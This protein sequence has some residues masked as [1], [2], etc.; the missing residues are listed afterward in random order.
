MRE[1]SA[2]HLANKWRFFRFFL[3]RHQH[4]VRKSH[5]SSNAHDT[6]PRGGLPRCFLAGKAVAEVGQMMHA[7]T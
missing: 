2:V 3:S 1:M 5:A 4:K 7:A 6:R